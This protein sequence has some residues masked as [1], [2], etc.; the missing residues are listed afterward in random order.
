[1][2]KIDMLVALH[3][4]GCTVNE[5]YTIWNQFK[6]RTSVLFMFAYSKTNLVKKQ[7]NS[8]RG[9]VSYL[10]LH[11]V[12]VSGHRHNFFLYWGTYYY[13]M[14]IFFL[15]VENQWRKKHIELRMINILHC[16]NPIVSVK[17]IYDNEGLAGFFA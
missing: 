11:V 3:L 1:M 13:K 10:P 8:K 14:S 6:S 9:L 16:R 4:F 2:Q 7:I 12:V 5:M 15:S 17:E